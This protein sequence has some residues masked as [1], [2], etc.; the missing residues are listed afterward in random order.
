MFHITF[1]SSLT[2]IQQVRHFDKC[3]WQHAK[4]LCAPAKPRAER[5]PKQLNPHECRTSAPLVA[6]LTPELI[7]ERA[8]R[9]AEFIIHCRELS[10]ELSPYDF[11]WMFTNSQRTCS[12]CRDIGETVQVRL[13][14]VRE[15]PTKSIVQPMELGHLE[16]HIREIHG[17]QPNLRLDSKEARSRIFDFMGYGGSWDDDDM[18]DNSDEDPYD[19]TEY[20]F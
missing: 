7:E 12:L 2:I 20:Y 19:E 8:T 16:I 18:F 15:C 6:V 13:L 17:I 3:N 4:A 1:S 11:G 14:I 9:K 5:N 10:Q